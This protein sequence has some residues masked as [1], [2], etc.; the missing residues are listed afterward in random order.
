MTREFR[1]YLRGMETSVDR[2][3]LTAQLQHSDPTYEAWK[4]AYADFNEVVPT[5]FRSYLRG[6]ETFSSLIGCTVK[7]LYSDP[8]YEAWKLT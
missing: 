5:A 8:T 1:S 6:M 4:L 3:H 7:N 2:T